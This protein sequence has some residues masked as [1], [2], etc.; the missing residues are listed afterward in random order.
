[1]LA[2]VYIKGDNIHFY[3]E[4]RQFTDLGGIVYEL[5][6]PLLD[7]ICCEPERFDE[8]FSLIASAFDNEYAHIGAKDP[9]FI[10]GLKESMAEMQRRE[11]YV[12]FFSQMFMEFIFAF[13]ESPRQAI[14]ALKRKLPGVKEKLQWAVDFEWPESTSPYVEVAIFADKEKRLYRAA[15]DV[16]AL[17]SKHLRGL[18]GF[19]KHEVEVLIH[20]RKEIEVPAGRSIDYVDILDEYHNYAFKDGSFYLE[21]PFRT[22]YGRV[23]D[24][25]VEQLYSIY[26]IEDLFRFEL[27]KMIEHEIFIKKCKNCERFFIPMRRVDAEYCNRIYGGTQRRCNEIG[28]MIQY[29]KR[30]AE[31]PILEAHKK[32]YRR[33]NSRTRT[34]KMTQS[35]FM[36][37]SDEAARKRD[38]C[39]A[40]KLSFDDFVAW[41]EQGRVRKP[42]NAGKG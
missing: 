34:K 9:A 21:R 38:E 41:L 33:F 19:I 26:D 42:R 23:A 25:K 3:N 39:L 28:A 15:M 2:S 36:A 7:F 13:I 27:I 11:V 30:V 22:F 6:K 20:Y 32:A 16:V 40:G 14:E 12:Y 4:N 31:N 17:M 35:E 8:S 5:G 10:E 1:M 37:W 24:G 18:Q 29:E